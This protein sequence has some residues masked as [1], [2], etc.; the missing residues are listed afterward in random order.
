[1]YRFTYLLAVCVCLAMAI[2]C[3]SNDEDESDADRL[4]GQWQLQSLTDDTGDRTQDFLSEAD[5]FSATLRSDGTFSLLMDF[6]AAAE[7]AGNSDVLLTGT[8]TVNEST[9]QLAMTVDALGATLPAGYEIVTDDTVDLIA[10]AVLI[11]PIF[12][13]L[14]LQGT[15]RARL[16]RQ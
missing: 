14:P 9:R 13:G 12:G 10:P 5:G 11:N 3:D 15:V 6:N 4:V 7:A 2:G 1:M 8:Y 16:A